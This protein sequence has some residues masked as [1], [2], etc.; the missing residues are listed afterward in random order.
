MVGS[1]EKSA[2]WA[3]VPLKSLRGSK[4]RLADIL[5]DDER[6]AL[7]SAM[8][9]DVLAALSATPGIDGIMVVS[10][11]ASVAKLASGF[12]ASVMPE[13]EQVGLSG[14]VATAAKALAADQI[15]TMVVV[16]GDIPLAS[17]DELQALI[18]KVAAAPSITI[19]PCR[20]NDGT[21][22]MI[23]S[24]PDIIPF[25]YGPGSCAAHQQAAKQAGIDVVVV[26]MPGLALDIDLA[27]DLA[28]LLEH[29]K[30]GEVGPATAQ[31]LSGIELAG[32]LG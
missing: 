11:D 13:S 21:N 27:A 31:F 10:D 28:T 4:K 19:A 26:N 1:S 9:R 18:E 5:D 29:H 22:V 14:A 17:P 32:R 8:A 16:H 12:G 20:G 3:V 24:P 30:K 6:E 2:V 15:G 25:L 7:V 23:C